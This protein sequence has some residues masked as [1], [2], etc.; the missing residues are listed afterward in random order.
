MKKELTFLNITIKI[1]R[2]Q[3]IIDIFYEKTN[4]HQY[5]HFHSYNPTHTTRN[6]ILCM[7]RRICARVTDKDL[8]E[9][10]L[11]KFKSNLLLRHYPFNLTEAG[12][13]QAKGQAF[14][15]IELRNKIKNRKET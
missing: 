12:T 3:V 9:T 8:I 13:K 14:A 6:I 2:N 10:R 5:I 1:V 4:T 7:V 11:N 15:N